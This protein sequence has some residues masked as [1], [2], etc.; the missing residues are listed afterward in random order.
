MSQI[1]QPMNT[2]TK[3]FDLDNDTYDE[4]KS[5]LAK[6]GRPDLIEALKE[7]RDDDYVPKEKKIKEYYEYYDDGIEEVISSGD[8]V[9]DKEGFW[10]LK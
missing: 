10:S 1:H 8:V 7:S 3:T 2:P 6:F 9:V 5:I 4:I